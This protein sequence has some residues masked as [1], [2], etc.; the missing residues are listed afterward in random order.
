MSRKN[1]TFL[2]LTITAVFL[3]TRFYNLNKA[4]IWEDNY[5]WLYRINHYPWI[6]ELNLKGLNKPD[7]DMEYLG[8]ISYH[9]GVTLMSFSG[10]STR[11]GKKVVKLFD[12]NY[13][14]CGYFEGCQ[15]LHLELFLA[16]LPL[17]LISSVAFFIILKI[18]SEKYDWISMVIFG[19]IVISEP[20]LFTTSR[21]LHLDFIQSILIMLTFALF[22]SKNTW[23]NHLFSGIAFGL[24]ALTRFAS[25]VFLPSFLLIDIKRGKSF[26]KNFLG[27]LT[28]A[29][30]V[31]F[32]MYPAMW[33][34]PI[35][36]VEY[37]LEGSVESSSDT[38]DIAKGNQLTYLGGVLEYLNKSNEGLSTVWK[39]LFI[40]SVGSL[41]YKTIKGE[42]YEL[43]QIII[44]F[45]L[46]F[47]FINFSGKR[48]FRYLTPM[49]TG[50]S[51][52]IAIA[53]SEII[54]VITSN[55][56]GSKVGLLKG[57]QKAKK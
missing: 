46:Y 11:Y 42:S 55:W 25:I 26:L 7:R 34:H 37:I 41:I 30:F 2:M 33:F 18:I 43:L 16:K 28:S 17:I 3:F 5:S 50:F 47:L 53:W 14:Q 20:I 12:P 45:G 32:L 39:I 54:R 49:I 56:L 40:I 44:F 6:L 8:K 57:S 13:V 24:T 9:P 21:D 27:F 38:I 52:F 15:Y 35:K 10:I 23:K 29:T 4:R 22:I 19:L 51:L 1:K 36:T 48:Y 31:F